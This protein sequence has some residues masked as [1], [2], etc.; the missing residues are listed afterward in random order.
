MN[1]E[2]S[3]ALRIDEETNKQFDQLIKLTVRT[4]SD[5]VR[6]LIREEWRRVFGNHQ[7]VVATTEGERVQE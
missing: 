5:M 1:K 3:I 2:I 4:R 6:W 7:P